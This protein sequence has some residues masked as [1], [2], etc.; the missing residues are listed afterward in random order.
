MD[1]HEW[2]LAVF[3]AFLLGG[4]VASTA[5]YLVS[6]SQPGQPAQISPCEA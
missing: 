4:A 1:T 3:F 6:H 2:L 5:A